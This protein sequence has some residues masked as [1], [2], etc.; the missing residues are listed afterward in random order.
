MT[1]YNSYETLFILLS[2]FLLCGF[3][4]NLLVL[5]SHYYE[6]DTVARS[7]LLGLLLG[8]V[9]TGQLNAPLVVILSVLTSI[10]AILLTYYIKK[11]AKIS[12]LNVSVVI[13][14]GFLVIEF[15]YALK[16]TDISYFDISSIYLGETAFSYLYRLNLF[17]RDLGALSLY[18]VAAAF[19]IDIVL[20]LIFFKDM[21][22]DIFDRAYAQAQGISK[23]K[24]DVVIMT[25]TSI[26][27]AVSFQTSGIFLTT[28]FFLAP[29]VIARLY[30]I[31]DKLLV[32]LAI[33]ICLLSAAIGL[34]INISANVF[35]S[36]AIV[37]VLGVML[38]L[39]LLFAPK[40]GLLGYFKNKII[41][42]K[43]LEK[44]LVML[45]LLEVASNAIKLD[46]L[47]K[48]LGIEGGEAIQNSDS[49]EAIYNKKDDVIV[50]EKLA[51]QENI[52]FISY[53][54]KWSLDKSEKVLEKLK[55]EG[56]IIFKKSY[57]VPSKQGKEYLYSFSDYL[58]QKK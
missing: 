31:N 20:F 58:L 14:S 1:L 15:L 57:L 24:I 4:G 36:S 21:R 52:G 17:G 42:K 33:L 41:F 5:R 55:S 23:R 53:V 30:T 6:V 7:S 51:M 44:Y 12:S 35:M 11:L 25:M 28:A 2:S 47:S 34:V 39:S 37:I 3:V 13:Y 54:F 26:A 46:A 10:M 56:S 40:S 38:L 29:T 45:Y 27:F 18:T 50:D 9:I 43:R 16:Y 8:F 19:I 49:K 22:I 32:V 48:E